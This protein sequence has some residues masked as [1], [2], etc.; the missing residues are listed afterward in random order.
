MNTGTFEVQILGCS[1]ALP[2]YNRFP[3]SH[4]VRIHDHSYMVDCGEGTQFQL[5]KYGIKRSRIKNI[6]ITHLHGDHVFGLPGLITSYN[7]INRQD[8]LH[9]YGPVGIKK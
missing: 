6:F 3:S 7:L 8:D 5:N 1:A 9:I 2:A 4:I